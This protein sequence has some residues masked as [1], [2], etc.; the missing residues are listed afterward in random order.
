MLAQQGPHSSCCRCLPAYI[1]GVAILRPEGLR[2]LRPAVLVEH[3]RIGDFCVLG[4]QAGGSPHIMCVFQTPQ[5]AMKVWVRPGMGL[6]SGMDARRT[7]GM[8][9]SFDGDCHA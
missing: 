3:Q 6:S 1:E 7:G 5:A 4:K 2:R 9:Q 8:F